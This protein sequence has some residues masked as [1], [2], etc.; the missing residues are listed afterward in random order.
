MCGSMSPVCPD[1][2]TLATSG[3]PCARGI[4]ICK[5]RSKRPMCAA[6]GKPF[7]GS[8]GS[9]GTAQA[10]QPGTL[11]QPGGGYETS[12]KIRQ[13]WDQEPRGF[14]REALVKVPPTSTGQKLPVVIDLHGAGGSANLRRLR[15]IAESFVI[16]AASGY[17]RFWNVYSEASKADDV[18]F[19][20]RLIKKVGEDIPEADIDNVTIVG[21]SNGAGMIYRLL[22]ETK[23]PRPFKRVIPLVSSLINIQYHDDSF[24]MSD[25]NTKL[26]NIPTVPDSPGPQILHIHGTADGTVPYFGGGGNFLGE[27]V[28]F[29]DAQYS[30]FVW[31][32][33][34]GYTGDKLDDS[35][36]IEVSSGVFKYEYLGGQVVHYKMVDMA[37]GALGSQY[38]QFIMDTIRSAASQ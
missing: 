17:K 27:E 12:L 38:K 35:A 13:T 7:G 1:G 28:D 16:V 30:D 29:L 6:G 31:A 8:S 19:L 24:W 25:N 3:R 4:P 20:Q 26:W 23:N 11:Q 2:S 22:M 33:S 14:D 10:Q 32:K 15:D 21:T 9:T 5:D 18:E 34:F 36:G 37:H